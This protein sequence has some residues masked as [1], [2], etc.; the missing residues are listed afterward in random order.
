M[1]RAALTAASLCLSLVG[2]ADSNPAP[3]ANAG[4]DVSASLSGRDHLQITT[5]FYPLEFLVEQ[6]G[7][8]AATVESLTAPGTEPHDLELTPRQVARLGQNDLVVYLAGF[9]P[10]VDEA[11]KQR[12]EA[13]L[14][15][16]AVTPLKSGYLPVEEGVAEPDER[17]A[18]P[19]VWLEPLRYADIGDAVAASMSDLAPRHRERF[20]GRA[21]ILRD[22][23]QA[24]DVEFRTGLA[25]CR[26]R[27][28]VTSHN[29]FGYLA[30]A[31]GLEQVSLTGLTP[32]Q[33]ASPGRLGEVATYARTNG[34]TT[35]FFEDLVSP[36]VAESLA[37]EVGAKAVELS[38]LE[39]APEVGDYFTQMRQ[40]LTKLR[41][42]LGCAGA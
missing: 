30:S 34:V 21:K 25:D 31:Y 27:Q 7:G 22:R 1:L 41:S 37:A 13:S 12:S 28:I 40:T 36:A 29:A 32:D 19:H 39:G 10:A 18:D 8:D 26:R 6:L 33:E 11:V 16:G 38:P 15:V 3:A 23:L 5:A 17:G 4:V 35:I 9:Q 14:D 42:A 20:T 2:C 24:L